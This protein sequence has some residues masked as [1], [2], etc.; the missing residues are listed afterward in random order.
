MSL[1]GVKQI[2]YLQ[3]DFTAYKIGN[4]M[5]NLANPV[6]GAPGAPT[7]I[8]GADVGLKHFKLLNDANL[9]FAHNMTEAKARN[10]T[11]RAFYV[12]PDNSFVDFDPSV[13]SFLCTDA[14]RDLFEDGG[15][16]L[17]AMQLKFPHRRFPGT[18]TADQGKALSN[19]ECLAQARDFYRYADVEGYRGSPHKL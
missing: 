2:I 10:E 12:S 4:I 17:D 16:M 1:A 3:N 19:A 14:A 15:K 18:P 9:D 13:T 8:P 11:S 5:F 6:A 7:P